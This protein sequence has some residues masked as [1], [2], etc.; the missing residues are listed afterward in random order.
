MK[1]NNLLKNVIDYNKHRYYNFTQGIVEE[2]N[3]EYER[4]L[5]S[6]YNKISRIKKHL[7]F[8]LSHRQYSYFLT[9]TFDDNLIKR[10]DRTKRD[11]IKSVLNSIP[12]SL[13][14]LNI[15]YGKKTE[16]E[17][18]HCI[19]GTDFDIDYNSYLKEHYPCF[20]CC[21]PIRKN[22]DDIARLSK[23]VNKLSNHTC[24]DSTFNKRVVYNFKGFDS[25]PKP[26]DKFL[27]VKSC[28]KLGIM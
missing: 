10:C 8:L 25:F 12:D 7:I 11:I 6:R 4:I 24:K 26:F 16:R 13:Y 17:H 21:I 14:I 5:K 15:D 3:I 18:Y 27:Y 20:S 28:V 2:Q 19:L 9:F 23:Y 22:K 1:D